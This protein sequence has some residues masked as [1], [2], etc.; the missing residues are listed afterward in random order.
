MSDN[1]QKKWPIIIVYISHFAI[2][3]CRARL[4]TIVEGPTFKPNSVE[5]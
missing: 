5:R 4:G 2:V 3:E 1:D